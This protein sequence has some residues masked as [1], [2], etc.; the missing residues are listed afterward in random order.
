MT[1]DLVENQTPITELS[2]PARRVLGVLIEK[3][4]TTPEYYPLTLKAI[5]AGCNQKS[6]RSPTVNYSEEDVTDV[7]E[8]LRELGLV[9][10]VHTES[11]RTERF[12]HYLRKRFTLSEP[13]V[14]ILTE[15]LLRGRQQLG[16]L[17]TRAARMV[18]IDSL[19]LLRHELNG[20]IEM[21]LAQAS[22]SLERRGIEVD[23][24]LYPAKED[25]KLAATDEEPEH[26]STSPPRTIA[27]PSAASMPSPA[28][29]ST[30]PGSGERIA[31]LE[32]AVERLRE[33]NRGLRDEVD[34]VR[35]EMQQ[36]AAR[37]ED[38]KRD[39]GG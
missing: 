19:E 33:E 20:L 15:L 12:R 18:P 36:L 6:N 11:G 29:S 34:A 5:T 2:K 22:G 23:H 25:M 3:G 31:S 26:P 30:S 7:L 37:F 39:L 38:L 10:V 1:D 21:R 27:T 24:N 16:E 4:L 8:E 32:A 17:R 13:Q 35:D 9:A 14:A 28:A